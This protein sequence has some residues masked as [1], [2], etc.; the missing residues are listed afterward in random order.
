M[1]LDLAIGSHPR[2][3]RWVWS[4]EDFRHRVVRICKELGRSASSVLK[5]AGLAHDYLQPPRKKPELRKKPAN[6][7]RRINCVW[8]LANVLNC[9]PSD[10]LGL[11]MS[12]QL[13]F[14]LL[15][16]SYDAAEHATQLV[17]NL[18]KS[19]FLETLLVIYNRL[20]AR[21]AAGHD[22]HDQ[23]YLNELIEIL[24]ATAAMRKPK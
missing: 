8:D 3:E 7:G 16:L 10:L 17:R 11:V 24:R 9:H 21:R 12:A 13:E 1:P 18:D 5:E 15:Q 2:W 14:E 19:I 23:E 20:L 6:G 4:E 22:V